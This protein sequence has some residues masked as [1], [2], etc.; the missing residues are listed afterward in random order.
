MQLSDRCSGDVYVNASSNATYQVFFIRR[1]LAH[2]IIIIHFRDIPT[3]K[4]DFHPLIKEINYRTTR[5]WLPFLFAVFGLIQESP[6]G[7]FTFLS[8]LQLETPDYRKHRG[9]KINP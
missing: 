5:I 4:Q 1:N 6:N 8:I 9:N 2:L 3:L 7:K